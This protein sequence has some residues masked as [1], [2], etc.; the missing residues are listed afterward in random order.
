MWRLLVLCT[1]LALI[2]SSIA[3]ADN[4][5]IW[6]GR[7]IGDVN[8]PSENNETEPGMIN[9][10]S[11]DLEA[12]TLEGNDLG[13]AAGFDLKDGK[14]YGGQHII[15][16]DIFIDING[17]AQFG[18]STPN[19]FIDNFG[20]EYA[21]KLNFGDGTYT[22]YE[23]N[24]NSNLTSTYVYNSPESDP[25]TLTLNGESS[26]S[27]GNF[28]YKDFL[29]TDYNSIDGISLSFLAPGTTFIS[30]VTM[31]CGN[32]N[33]MGSGT[34]TSVPEPSSI[35]FLFL[36]LSLLAVGLRRKHNRK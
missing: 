22:V 18:S 11:W 15:L 1:T 36:G 3:S 2:G 26:A 20:Y 30:H 17:D 34:T 29:G 33:L 32:D 16:G 9:T 27:S 24:G 35:G 23:L 7:G 6:D 21:V 14:W 12:F 10:Q 28:T 19:P 31:T 25:F 13:I 4:I 5:T 8:N